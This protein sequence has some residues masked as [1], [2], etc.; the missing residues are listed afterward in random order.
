MQNEM[1][2]TAKKCKASSFF[3]TLCAIVGFLGIA[4]CVTLWI[5]KKY[6]K[7]TSVFND[8]GSIDCSGDGEE[9]C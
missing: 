9:E 5:C 2:C 8:D 3:T 6:R 4:T 7:C 1:Q